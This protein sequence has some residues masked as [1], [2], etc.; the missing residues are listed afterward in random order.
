MRYTILLL[1]LVGC[2]PKEYC[3][4][5]SSYVDT[6]VRLTSAPDS[7]YSYRQQLAKV[8]TCGM[9]EDAMEAHTRWHTYTQ[10]QSSAGSEVTHKAAIACEKT[11]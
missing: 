10:T 7:P 1:L 5:C 4:H 9:T 8:D 11:D 3:W 6:E 2:K